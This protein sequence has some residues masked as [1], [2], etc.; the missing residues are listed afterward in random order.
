MLDA[1]L[2]GIWREVAIHM[3]FF[4]PAPL[5]VSQALNELSKREI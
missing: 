5:W 1:V 3:G 2:V 4:H